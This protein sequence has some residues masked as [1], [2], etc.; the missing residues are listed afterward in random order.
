MIIKLSDN[1]RKLRKEN[2]MTQEELA[3][4]LNVSIGVVSK[5]ERGASEPELGC[6]VNIAEVFKVSVDSLIGYN[7]TGDNP[8]DAADKIAELKRQLKVREAMELADESLIRFPNDFYVI[9]EAAALFAISEQAGCEPNYDK[10]ITLYKKAITLLPQDTERKYSETDLQ[11]GIALCLLQLGR[12]DE[13]IEVL[14]A[15]NPGGNSEDLLGNVYVLEKKDYDEGMQ[16]LAKATLYLIERFT[17]V[18]STAVIAYAGKKEFEKMERV[19][20]LFDSVTEAIAVDPGVPTLFYKINSMMMAFLASET[21]KAGDEKRAKVYMKRAYECGRKY[22]ASPECSTDNILCA[23]EIK[24]GAVAFDDVGKIALESVENY[25]KE[26]DNPH[27]LTI[28]KN[29][30][31]EEKNKNE[32]SECKKTEK[33]VHAK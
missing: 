11:T 27:A 23:C 19:C 10:A 25:L 7:M 31:E 16:H 1:L 21:D 30:I 8:K 28:W 3:E 5:W 33:R 32:K 20:G 9:V 2:A 6:L 24:K 14:K 4:R 29:V 12:N 15:N 26:G 17:R 22:D 18:A 13:A